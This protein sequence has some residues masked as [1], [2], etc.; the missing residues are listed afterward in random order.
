[1]LYQQGTQSPDGTH[2][3]MASAAMDQGGNI[4]LGYTA[5]ST[6][7]SPSM[8]AATRRSNDPLGTMAQGEITLVGSDRGR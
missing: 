8:R 2:R 6:H 4:A 3:W 1:L 7:V 5:S